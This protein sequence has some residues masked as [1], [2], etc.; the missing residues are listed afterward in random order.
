MDRFFLNRSGLGVIRLSGSV[1]EAEVV[2]GSFDEPISGL[3]G[4]HQLWNLL[5]PKNSARCCEVIPPGQARVSGATDH[6]C[7][8]LRDGGPVLECSREA[9][10]EAETLV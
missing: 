5:T 6:C 2:A 4:N 7:C 3:H 1:L 9:V 10:P 8:Y